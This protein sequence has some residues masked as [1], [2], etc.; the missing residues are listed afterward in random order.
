VFNNRL[1]PD[2]IALSSEE[3]PFLKLE[4]LEAGRQIELEGV[5]ITPVPVNHVVPTFGFILED[6]DAAVV[7][8]SDTGPTEAIW[9]YA[10][11]TPNL[12]AVFLEATFP[13]SLTWLAEVSKHLTPAMFAREIKKLKQPVAVYA[14][15]LKARF[16]AEVIKELLRLGM[17]ALQIGQF[18][19]PYTF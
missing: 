8:S 13:Q 11:R 9:E 5:R 18:G 10:N 3:S 4:K 12:K 15:H 7:L 6:K 16:R 1:W 14:V 2:F 17:P 19:K